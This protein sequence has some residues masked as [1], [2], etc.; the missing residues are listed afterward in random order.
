VGLN[1]FAHEA[2]IH[3]DGFLKNPLCYEIMKPEQVGVPATNL[4]LGKHSGRHALHQRILDLGYED[5]SR[6]QLDNAYEAFTTMADGRKGL[7]NDDI[8]TLLDDLGFAKKGAAVLMPE[9]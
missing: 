5:V 6:D 2:G 3:Q 8:V 7:T 4:V 1:A 9:R